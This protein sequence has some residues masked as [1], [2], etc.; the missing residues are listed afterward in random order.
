MCITF[1]TNSEA[2]MYSR[3][4]IQWESCVLKASLVTIIE[5]QIICDISNSIVI[6]S[7]NKCWTYSSKATRNYLLSICKSPPLS[8]GKMD[9]W[10]TYQ[11]HNDKVLLSHYQNRHLFE[12]FQMVYL[13]LITNIIFHTLHYR[14]HTVFIFLLVIHISF[15][16]YV[17]KSIDKQLFVNVL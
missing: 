17:S 11:N 2:Y 14:A 8:N 10:C 5:F 13:P 4:S 16:S 7:R 6:N 12:I 3:P 1:G 15:A 9:L